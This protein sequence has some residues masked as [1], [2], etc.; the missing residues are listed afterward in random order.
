VRTRQEEL[1]MQTATMPQLDVQRSAGDGATR[2]SA[3][4]ELDASNAA[5]LKAALA[6]AIDS[7]ASDAAGIILL[8]LTGL[9]FIDS[10]GLGVLVMG[11]KRARERGCR[12]RIVVS[13]PRIRRVL[14]LTGLTRVLDLYGTLDGALDGRHSRADT[15]GATA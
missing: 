14:Q 15:A 6:A 8:D 12:L 2:L 9:T 13:H 4:G 1:E 11:Q 3:A 7:A 5:R 10:E